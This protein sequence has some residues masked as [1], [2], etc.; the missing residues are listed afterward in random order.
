MSEMM[1]A[2]LTHPLVQQAEV[3]R[4]SVAGQESCGLI[5][6]RLI[7]IRF[8]AVPL[9]TGTAAGARRAG[10]WDALLRGRSLRRRYRCSSGRTFIRMRSSSGTGRGDRGRGRRGPDFQLGSRLRRPRG[11]CR[12]RSSPAFRHGLFGLSLLWITVLAASILDYLVA[13]A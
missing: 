2:R 1:H 6:S 5:I 7:I 10:R 3:G 11:R 13:H 4:R 12:R 8:V 9:G